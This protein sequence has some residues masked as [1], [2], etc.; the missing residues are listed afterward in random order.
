MLTSVGCH[1]YLKESK[2]PSLVW[3]YSA[4]TMIWGQLRRNLPQSRLLFKRHGAS[5]TECAVAEVNAWTRFLGGSKGICFVIFRIF[6]RPYVHATTSLKSSDLVVS[7]GLFGSC[8]PTNQRPLGT[9][10][11]HS[12]ALRASYSLVYCSIF[13]RY[14]LKAFVAAKIWW[15]T[16][17]LV[18][19]LY[20]SSCCDLSSNYS[21]SAFGGNVEKLA[22]IWI[23]NWKFG[24]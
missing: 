21:Y 12:V 16:N 13:T 11:P 7:L 22:V 4:R 1:P 15:H 14:L 2:W 9:T 3:T 6:R 10:L 5:E 20:C 8:S 24:L 17:I 19:F 18:R 23:G